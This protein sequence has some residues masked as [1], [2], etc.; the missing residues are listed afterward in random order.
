MEPFEA[1]DEL[2]Q[3]VFAHFGLAIYLVQVFETGMINALTILTATEN[4]QPREVWEKLYVEH[5]KLTFGNLLKK[6]SAKAFFPSDVEAQVLEIKK[7]RD[8]ITHQFFRDHTI[9]FNAASGCKIMIA[10][11]EDF[12]DRIQ[13][14][15]KVVD[16]LERAS[17]SRL[18]FS[19]DQVDQL[20]DSLAEEMLADAKAGR[21]DL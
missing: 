13:S 10:E 19:L 21:F 11:L 14:V 2:V 4:R 18:G 1:D 17:L 3:E 20:M 16:K 9:S 5:E 8:H 15:G 12:R 6:L 7:R